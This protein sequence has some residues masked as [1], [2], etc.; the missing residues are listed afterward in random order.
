MFE[1]CPTS[2]VILGICVL[3]SAG[4]DHQ[5]PAS[6]GS[7]SSARVITDTYNLDPFLTSRPTDALRKSETSLAIG[8]V[9]CRQTP[10][11]VDLHL[12]RQ[13]HE[14]GNSTEYTFP[15]G[16]LML[17]LDP[18]GEDLW[19]QQFVRNGSRYVFNNDINDFS[20]AEWSDG[21]F[22][23]KY[24]DESKDA[25]YKLRAGAVDVVEDIGTFSTTPPITKGATRFVETSSTADAA[26]CI[27]GIKTP[28]GA[29][30][31][32]RTDKKGHA[33]LQ[34]VK[35]AA[36]LNSLVPQ[37]V[38]VYA[39]IDGEMR[40]IGKFQLTD[41]DV[42]FAKRAVLSDVGASTP[43]TLPSGQQLPPPP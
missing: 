7:G 21:P 9:D 8:S 33:E 38:T 31:T 29:I 42:A 16:H 15:G 43:T 40:P 1:A 34:L 20:A 4:C 36:E 2:A 6:G 12:V 35:T 3:V 27:V 5:L 19:N 37:D 25:L 26:E 23:V 14:S 22:T 39:S 18:Y 13:Q 41:A 10:C 11:V 24:K 30:F 32:A 17:R 28:S